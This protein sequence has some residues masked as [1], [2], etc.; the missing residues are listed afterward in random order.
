V[1]PRVVKFTRRL[2]RRT[3]MQ[4]DSLASFADVIFSGRDTESAARL[5][6]A[7]PALVHTRGYYRGYTDVTPL[8]IAAYHST[9]W[10]HLIENLVK[11]GADVNAADASGLTPLHLASAGYLVGAAGESV[12]SVKFLVRHGANVNARTKSGETPLHGAARSNYYRV[13]RTLLELGADPTLADNQGVTPA[14]AA[15]QSALAAILAPKPKG[16]CAGSAALLF[17]LFAITV[18]T[19]IS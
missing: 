12:E 8:H 14:Q 1:D 11:M 10:H 18:A 17:S 4:E 15:S 16:G 5:L 7:N 2:N 6:A 13:A 9:R 3:A 19:I